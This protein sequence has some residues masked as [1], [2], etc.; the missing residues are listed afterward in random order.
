MPL[1][2]FK[3]DDCKREFEEL[4]SADKRDDPF[5]CPDCG[6]LAKRKEVTSFGVSTKINPRD[7]L[8]SRKEI[9]RAVG[10]AS[11]KRWNTYNDMWS[12]IYKE[13]REARREGRDIREI[14]VRDKGGVVPFENLGDKKEQGFRKNYAKEYTEQI[15]KK[16]KDGNK[17]PV[18]MKKTG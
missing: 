6:N 12:R 8:V 1:Y 16:G 18:V 9:D 7:T 5:S 11:E 17:T 14:T 15:T 10:A 2:V 4:C 3:C 13:R